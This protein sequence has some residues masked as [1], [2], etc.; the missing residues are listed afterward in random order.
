MPCQITLFNSLKHEISKNQVVYIGVNLTF[1]VVFTPL[2]YVPTIPPLSS[3]VNSIEERGGIVRIY[4][5][6][7]KTTLK[8]TITPMDTTNQVA[9]VLK[10]TLAGL[11][12]I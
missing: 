9:A 6:G 2:E 3:Y 4:S 10:Q 7:V 8:V 11:V 12:F 5:I 1:K